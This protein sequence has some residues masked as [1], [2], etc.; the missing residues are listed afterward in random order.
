MLKTFTSDLRRNITKVLCL[1]VGMAVGMILIA[2]IYYEE[3]YD[4]FFQDSD[5]I[6]LVYEKFND[7]ENPFDFDQTSG[8]YAPAMK[9]YLPQV[10]TS[11]R[12]T[13]FSSGDVVLDDQRRFDSEGIKVADSCLFDVFSNK[14][15]AGDPHEVLSVNH[16]CMI[17]RSRADKIGGN[18]TGLEITIPKMS[19]DFKVTIG[20]VY[21]DFPKNSTV[22]NSIYVSISTLEAIGWG[23]AENWV[24]NDAYKSFVKLR[25]DVRVEDL[26][27]GIRRMLE[28]N[29][30]RHILDER[31]MDIGIKPLV[32]YHTSGED[33]KEMVF[34]LSILV[35][36]ILMCSSV[37]YLLIVTGQISSR[38]KSMAVR[39]CFGTGNA[40]LFFMVIGESMAYIVVSFCLACVLIFSLGDLCKELLGLSPDQLFAT[41]YIWAV[42]GV[43]MLMLLLVTGVIPAVIYCRTPVA[44][45][46]R[47]DTRKR[48]I[49]KLAMLALQF[50]V[51]GFLFSLL[52]LIGRQYRQLTNFDVGYDYS[53]IGMISLGSN[54]DHADRLKK[55][56]LRLGCVENV[57]GA[58]QNFVTQSSGGE[59]II[60]DN[61]SDKLQIADMLWTDREIF[62]VLGLKFIQGTTFRENADTTLHEVVVEERMI[63]ALRTRY[64]ID[65]PAIVG[66]TFKYGGHGELRE[67]TICGVVNNIHRGG[68]VD[69]HIDR[70]PGIFFPPENNAWTLYV[71]FNEMNQSNMHMAQEVIDSIFGDSDTYIVPYKNQFER[72]TYDIEKFATAVLAV[73][74]AILLIA[75]SGLLGYVADDV[76]SRS[77]E[78]AIRKVTGTSEYGIL[79][80]F[81]RDVVIVALPSLAI[82]A[83][84]AMIAGKSWLSRFCDQVSLSPAIFL[85]CVIVLLLLILVMVVVNSLKVA[86]SNPVRFLRNE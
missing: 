82:G 52:V 29:V 5:R 68:F 83:V 79:K 25:K 67:Y 14:I 3:T 44:Q 38:S 77:K 12:Y 72:Y 45:A 2:K 26:K 63:D 50:V 78:I 16:S 36:L 39:K 31:Y 40:R 37:N 24:G 76:E 18:V 41:K 69:E 13:W 71:R 86:R 81:C 11:T 33:V 53:D 70:R 35:V 57:A 15:I 65:S 7:P 48:K 56:L 42:E 19:D 73:G 64:G 61:E 66:K 21:E 84:A 8:A 47:G 23:G 75:L 46:F 22:P 28:E 80:L 4:A 30:D 62:D 6:F 17:P 1:T 55:E 20:G 58:T 9:R 60:E 74:I 43:T 59:A 51:S 10:E 85:L 54:K 34:M 32:G 27:S 49:W